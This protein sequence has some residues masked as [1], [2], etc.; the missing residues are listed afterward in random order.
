M[1]LKDALTDALKASRDPNRKTSFGRDVRVK[2]EMAEQAADV[3]LRKLQEVSNQRVELQGMVNG[4][5]Y[6][7][8]RAESLANQEISEFRREVHKVLNEIRTEG[9]NLR[10]ERERVA[11]LLLA[12]Q[13]DRAGTIKELLDL[14]TEIR[15]E[16][17]QAKES[18][19]HQISSFKQE[20]E[21]ER[22]DL[23]RGK[24]GNDLRSDPGN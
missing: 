19:I 12:T 15:N 1:S 3:A 21:H 16:A 4:M 24:P 22:I 18:V 13:R 6:M 14:K 20:Q 23:D 5:E 17:T 11:E 10:T 8:H 2:A 9:E 7:L